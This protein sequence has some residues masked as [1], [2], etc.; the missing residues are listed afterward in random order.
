MATRP[1]VMVDVNCD[2]GESYGAFCIG[3]DAEILPWISSANVACGFHGGDALVMNRTVQMAKA[4]GVAVGAHPSF[5][6]LQGFGRR[7]M[8]VPP[9]ELQA[10]LVYQIGALRAFTEIH[11]IALQHVKPHGALS[12]MASENPDVAKVVAEAVRLVN[13][14]LILLAPFGSRLAQAG[15][16][17]GLKV[18]LEVFADRR[19]EADGSLRSRQ[20]GNAL[21][22][23]PEEV[24]QHVLGMVLEN[25]ITAVDGLHIPVKAHSVCIHGDSPGAVEFARRVHQALEAHSVQI[26]PLAQV[27]AILRQDD[28]D[29]GRRG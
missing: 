1:Q 13:P 25:R 24:V 14:N 18:A 11:G 6:D 27:I 3:S 22:T 17:A 23:Q 16:E 28:G 2:M 29:A 26:Q 15:K 5:P 4:R 9:A 12:N 19:Y 20:H 21:L 10:I 8:D 7:R